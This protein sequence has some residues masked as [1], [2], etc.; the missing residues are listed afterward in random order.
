MSVSTVSGTIQDPSGQ[1]FAN[2]TWQLVFKPTPN[3]PGL[4]TDGGVAFIT[5]FGGVLDNT[6]SFSQAGVAR[7][8]TIA[9]AGSKWTLVVSPNANGQA[10]SV[11]L[12]IN[13]GAFSASA[14]I[15]AVI[16]NVVVQATSVAHAYKDSEVIPVPGSGGLY[17][18]VTLKT[19]KFWDIINQVW[20]TV[21]QGALP[22][23]KAAIAS[24]WLR[25]YDS[26]TGLFTASQPASADISDGTGTGVVARQTNAALIT[27]NIGD[28]TGTSVILKTGAG[29]LPA[30]IFNDTTGGIAFST[31]AGKTWVVGNTGNLNGP[32]G[33]ALVLQGGTSGFVALNPPSVAGSSQL[34]VPAATDTLVGKATTDTL[35]NKRMTPRQIVMADA[36]SV[37]P[38]SD[39]ADINT[40]VSTQVGGTLTVNAPTGTP[41]D[42]QKLILRLKSTNAQT[43]S[44]NGTYS[45]STSVTAPTTL[46]AGKTDYIGLMWNATNTKWDVVAVDQGH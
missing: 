20:L 44:F 38:T 42:G 13:S 1:V 7:N 25:S 6:G 19:L 8:D 4:F 36:T 26:T 23:T 14:A 45:F 16:T 15:N 40:F 9:P 39:T 46:S 32:G 33:N 27:P 12:N 35:I 17:F 37:T 18:D 28:A 24:N 34:T 3:T 41:T 31:N 43:Y 2:G 30:T 5:L 11:D 21:P 22:V 29:T 10:Y